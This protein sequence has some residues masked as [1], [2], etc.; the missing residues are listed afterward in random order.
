MLLLPEHS[1]F[2]LYDH[3]LVLR[4]DI[5]ML[6]SKP[7]LNGI[8][9]FLHLVPSHRS[10]LVLL[11]RS[12]KGNLPAAEDIVTIL[13]SDRFKREERILISDRFQ[14]EERFLETLGEI[15]ILQEMPPP[16]AMTM[17]HDS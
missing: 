5:F 3:G 8:Y 14:R 17:R 2:Q 4:T 12:R 15:L 13:I 1:S 16:Q 7:M 6:I 11:Q 10:K 9:S